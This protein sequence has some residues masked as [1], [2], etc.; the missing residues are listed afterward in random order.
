[1]YTHFCSGNLKGRDSLHRR[2]ILY[3]EETM[4][5]DMEWIYVVQNRKW[6][7]TVSMVLGFPS[8]MN[9]RG[10]LWTSFATSSFSRTLLLA[11]NLVT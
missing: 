3:L 5:G 6:W 11:S 9:E 8:F 7:Y 4:C 2:I 1:M 10:I